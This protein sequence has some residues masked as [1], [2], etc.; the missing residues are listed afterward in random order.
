ML[1]IPSPSH[2]VT[3]PIN[4]PEGNVNMTASFAPFLSSQQLPS[5]SSGAFT[6]SPSFM[7]GI[8]PPTANTTVQE[9][10]KVSDEGSNTSQGR[11]R[12]GD[13]L[14][15][16]VAKPAKKACSRGTENEDMPGESAAGK[17]LDEGTEKSDEVNERAG[18]PTLSGRIP[19][20][21]T[22]LAEAGYQGEK[23]GVRPRKVQ[24]T[25]K[26]KS[27][28]NATKPASKATKPASKATAK[29]PA[30]KKVK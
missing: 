22:H 2:S 24:P 26:P 5:E 4:Q 7:L 21:P 30:K 17:Q 25:K 27:K 8:F 13:E 3:A 28:G 15:E 20:M 9:S 18:K 12:K 23:K 16:L 6:E 29:T 1:E 11:K 19:L 10:A 14:D